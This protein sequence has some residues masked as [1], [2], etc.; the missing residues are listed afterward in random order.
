MLRL[1]FCGVS[2]LFMFY[3]PVNGQD[4]GGNDAQ[5]NLFK[6]GSSDASFG[7]VR[8]FDNRYTGV[9]GTPFYMETW[10]KGSL[11]IN[12]GKQLSNVKIKYDA[13]QDELIIL[14]SSGEY[15]V[16][17]KQVKSFTLK[18]KDDTANINFTKFGHPKK[19][20]E[21][22]FYR[23]VYSG[24]IKLLEQSN[25]IFEKANF[26]GA[27]SN[28]KRYDEFKKYFAFYYVDENSSVPV[29]LKTT[30]NSLIKIFPKHKD[31]IKSFIKANDYSCKSEKDLISILK[32]YQEIE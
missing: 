17:K 7:I 6:I 8:K 2:L 15:F 14:T 20:G 18:S 11:V 21:Y 32:F 31:Q 16:P 23:V 29:K 9:Q 4:M 19:K 30:L 3:I 12:N 13:Y 22:Q 24:K 26:E 25:V 28:D 27:Y 1:I 5:E 10:S